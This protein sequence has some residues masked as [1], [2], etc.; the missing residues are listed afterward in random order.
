MG[1]EFEKFKK[2]IF[3][4]TDPYQRNRVGY[5][6]T[7]IILRLALLRAFSFFCHYSTGSQYHFSNGKIIILHRF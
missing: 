1:I 3:R 4:P 6:E 2:I 7:K 5:G